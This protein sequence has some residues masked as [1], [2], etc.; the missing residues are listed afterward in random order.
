MK[1]NK[2]IKR[3]KFNFQKYGNP[4]ISLLQYILV[5]FDDIDHEE[6]NLHYR[7]HYHGQWGRPK[8]HATF[9]LAIWK[10]IILIRLF[11]YLSMLLSVTCMFD[12]LFSNDNES[13]A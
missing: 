7:E 4:T 1:W 11:E 9:V 2:I 5:S 12:E 13:K 3:D 8:C 6:N 10:K